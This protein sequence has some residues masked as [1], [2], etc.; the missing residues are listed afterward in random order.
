MPVPPGRY[1]GFGIVT[2]LY[3]LFTL[4]IGVYLMLVAL[5]FI[6]DYFI[7]RRLPIKKLKE[8]IP[9]PPVL[10]E[11]FDWIGAILS[12]LLFVILIRTLFIEAYTIP[13]PSM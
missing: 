1:I 8:I 5:P 9:L 4:W 6:F 2:V 7:T 10:R 11:T 3:T 12:A 13:T